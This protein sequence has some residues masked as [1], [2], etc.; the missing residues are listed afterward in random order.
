M[1]EYGK[2]LPRGE[3]Y[4]G[5]FYRFC[6]QHE[7]RFQRCADCQAWRHPPRECCPHCGAFAWRWEQVSG[8]G[9]VYSWTVVQRALHPAFAEDVPYAV[10]IVELAEG[11]R[12]VSRVLDLPPQELRLG[13]PVEV[14]FV[15]VT[16][17]VT[18][19]MFRPCR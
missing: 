16:P 19:P 9:Q 13:L 14:V 3:G 12:L 5:D 2:P 6:K 4:H 17:E 7:L 10:V 18:L 15:D 8:K 1:G 11:V